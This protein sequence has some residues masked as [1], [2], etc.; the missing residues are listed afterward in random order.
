MEEIIQEEVALFKAFIDKAEGK[1]LDLIN[2][3]NLPI[4]NALWKVTVGQRFEYED[5]N[6]IS[7]IERLTNLFKRVGRPENVL[8]MAFSW[9]VKM[10]PKFMERDKSI[11]VKHDIMNLMMK[12]IKDHQEMLDH[13]EP[14]DFIDKVLIE[15]QNTTDTNSSFYEDVGIENLANTLFDLFLVGSET[16]SETTSIHDQVSRSSEEGSDRTG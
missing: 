4:L 11:E 15:I 14:R 13:N 5:P 7:I 1:P 8:V 2:K 9:I 6:L 3:F 12:T 10:N 16:T